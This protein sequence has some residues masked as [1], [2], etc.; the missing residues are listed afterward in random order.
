MKQKYLITY[1]V[2]TLGEVAPSYGMVVTDDIVSWLE[3]CQE[4][5]NSEYFLI[6]QLPITAAEAKRID[7]EL[8]SM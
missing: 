1:A 8:N 4:F 5:G 3:G 7:G 2:R 6:N